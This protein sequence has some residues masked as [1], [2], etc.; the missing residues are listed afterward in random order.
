M[1][2]LLFAIA[3]IGMLQA[4]DAKL[5]AAQAAAD[6][7][8][9]GRIAQLQ[10]RFNAKMKAAA[11]EPQMKA[12]LE[13]AAKMSGPF[14]KYLD[15]PSH[16]TKAGIDVYVFPTEFKNK[17]TDMEISI[18]GENKVAGLYFRGRKTTPV[19]TE[20]DDVPVAEDVVT[21]QTGTFSLPGK[22]SLPQGNGP[23]P[24]VVIVHGS[25]PTGM[26]GPAIG[27]NTP[28][29]DLAWGLAQQGVAVLRYDKRTLVY[30]ARS[31]TGPKANIKDETIDDVLSA[32]AMLRKNAKIDPKRVFVLGHSLGG[33]LA[34]YIATLD[35]KLAGIISM[36]GNTR[37]VTD[38]VLEQTKYMASLLPDSKQFAGPLAEAEKLKLLEGADDKLYMGV[39]LS[40]FKELNSLLPTNFL[41]KVTM[42]I[43]VLQGER[44]YQVTMADFGIWKQALAGRSNARLISYK[45]SNHLFMKGFDKSTPAEYQKAGKV[46]ENVIEDIAKWVKEQK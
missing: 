18:D 7:M 35:P 32:V 30:G 44:D 3:T 26:D 27:P 1:Y 16:S 43:L 42:P 36:A 4:Q 9:N 46:Q 24:V 19:A 11:P 6:D 45:E 17:T 34:P 28:Y 13:Q 20:A 14:Q 23:F 2:K 25:G 29:R 21:V 33:Q 41:S 10:A 22:L 37:P 40:Y 12:A 8:A 5:A 31:M 15:K 38:L 39:P